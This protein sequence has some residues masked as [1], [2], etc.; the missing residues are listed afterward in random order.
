MRKI[1]ASREAGKF[2]KRVPPKHGRQLI[3]KIEMLA[4]DPHP[5]DSKPLKGAPYWRADSGEYRI[6]YQYD[7]TE[8][9]VHAVGKRNDDEVY[10]DLRRSR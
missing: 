10:R 4:A 5:P 6:I 8:L 7:D 3:G 1:R 2:L 9:Y